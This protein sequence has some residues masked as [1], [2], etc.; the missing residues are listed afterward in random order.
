M[1]YLNW[2]ASPLTK[3][4]APHLDPGRREPGYVLDLEI[5]REAARELASAL[6][7]VL[8]PGRG[9]LRLD[10]PDEWIM[11]WKWREDESRLLLAHPQAEEWVTTVALDSDHGQRLLESLEAAAAS[12]S[13]ETKVRI[14]ELGVV[15]S[16]SNVEVVITVHSVHL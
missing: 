5:G 14:G 16:V 3:R 11:F 1:A 8:V 9:E 12:Q 15:G 10:L 2:K 6:S 4:V 7:E 13:P